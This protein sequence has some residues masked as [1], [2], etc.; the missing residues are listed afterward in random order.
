MMREGD[1]ELIARAVCIVGGKLLV[2]RSGQ[3]PNTFLPGGH[4]EF[5][6]GAVA[7]LTRE[8]GEEMDKRAKMG[9]FLG[10]VEHVFVNKGKKHC[11]INLVFQCE[12]EGLSGEAPPAA[13]EP[14][15]GFEWVPLG[16]L[17]G[18]ALEPAPLRERIPQWLNVPGAS[19]H[20]WASTYM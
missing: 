15:I 5:G 16:E 2:C 20:H 14:Q 12:I 18:S 3:A 11:E 17:A 9:R 19:H 8:I 4:V 10:A 13:A 6:E 7:A 1:V